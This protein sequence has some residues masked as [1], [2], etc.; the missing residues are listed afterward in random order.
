MDQLV[1]VWNMVNLAVSSIWERARKRTVIRGVH[2]DVPTLLHHG[3]PVLLGA[4]FWLVECAH[5]ALAA[6]WEVETYL[7]QGVK[8]GTVSPMLLVRWADNTY[9]TW[10]LWN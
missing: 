7:T 5:R 10:R 1:K 2:D 9:Q 4:F 6:R 3:T 8:Q